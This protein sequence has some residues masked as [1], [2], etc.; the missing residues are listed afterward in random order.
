MGKRTGRQQILDLPLVL[1]ATFLVTICPICLVWWL[2]DLGA[3]TSL[4]VG[5]AIGVA[6]SFGLSAGG[7]ALWKARTSSRDVLF[8]ELMLWGWVQRWRAE[9]DLSNAT[10]VLGLTD[11]PRKEVLGKYVTH[12]QRT[13]LLTRFAS[14]L[15]VR[16]PYTHGHSRRVARHASNIARRM[17]LS[18]GEAAKI[19]T[20]GLVHDVGKVNIPAALL[21]KEGTLTAAEF[22][23]IKRHPAE[24]SDMVSKLGH[25]E[26]T[27]MVRHHHERLDGT[28]YPDGLAGDSIPLGARIL[29]VA[30]TFDAITSTRAYRRAS[31][32]RKALD[33][34][35]AD[36]GS[37]LDPEVVRAFRG[38]YTGRRPLALWTILANGPPRLASWLGG[39]LGTA[40]AN[41]VANVMATA[42]ATTAI[43]GA[44]AGPLVEA[45]AR[46]HRAPQ[47]TTAPAA[48]PPAR[49]RPLPWTVDDGGNRPLSARGKVKGSD[50][51]TTPSALRGRARGRGDEFGPPGR[52][53]GGGQGG[54]GNSAPGG[55]P[56]RTKGAKTKT[57]RERQK[58]KGGERAPS[59]TKSPRPDKA[60]TAPDART[61][62]QDKDPAKTAPDDNELLDPDEATTLPG[63]DEVAP[64][65]G[66]GPA[67]EGGLLP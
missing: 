34:L 26:L 17:G 36:A 4:W 16:D 48:T 42:A 33:I 57:D 49:Q 66:K 30:D 56:G 37:Q 35:A 14:A 31:V 29:A 51:T 60:P 20:A 58:T 27:A 43:G 2:R 53:R 45:P 3:V 28:G 32:H 50:K 21:H 18:A 23:V 47:A 64:R 54:V 13:G 52:A 22:Q 38:L 39:G 44:A 6:V 7:A 40:K 63:A 62:P 1:C 25:D 46:S 12:E 24:G 11:E 8:S 41:S 59:R 67:G 65:G 19:R 5:I 9:R 15:E 10:D 61:A 55:G